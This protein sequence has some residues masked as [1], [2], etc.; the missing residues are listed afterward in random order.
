MT[1][2]D[3]SGLLQL[4]RDKSASGRAEL[5]LAVSEIF[6]GQGEIWSDRERALSIEILRHLVHDFERT[7]RRTVAEQLASWPALPEDLAN[8]LANEDIEIAFPILSES[9]VLKDETLIEIIRQRTREHQ[10]AIVIRES[11][12]EAVSEEVVKT[13]NNDVI[14]RLLENQN[15]KISKK[16]MEYLV[17]EAKRVDTFREPIVRRDDLDPMLSRKMYLWVSAAL[18]KHLSERFSMDDETVDDLLENAAVEIFVNRGGS[19]NSGIKSDQLAES[20][21]EEGVANIELLVGALKD[22]EVSLFM[23]MIKKMTGLREQLVKRL[24]FEPGGE[25][26]AIACKSLDMD[27]ADF[28]IIFALSRRANPNA[29][30]DFSKEIR[31]ALQFYG[32]LSAEAANKVMHQWQRDAGYLAALRDLDIGA[33]KH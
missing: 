33:T 25:G 3:T 16:T 30:K 23:S 22:G 19:G 11:I 2:M 7:V 28:S 32:L 12:S 18:R 29:S 14:K 5:A 1:K 4:A 26:L 31:S 20:L 27:K 8:F 15:A 10:M 9:G 6:V 24:V 21:I 13:G 17:D